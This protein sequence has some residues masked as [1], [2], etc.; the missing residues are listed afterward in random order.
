MSK[1]SAFGLSDRLQAIYNMIPEGG[2]LCDVGTDHGF[3]PISL[4]LDGRIDGALA[5]DLREG[6]LSRAREH[7]AQYH[8]EDRIETR[9]SDGLKEVKVGECDRVSISGMGGRTMQDILSSR[10][11][12]AKSVDYLL[13]QPQSEI[14]EFRNFLYE[15]GFEILKEDCIFEDGKFYFLILV[16][17]S[18]KAP[19][20][21]KYK[22]IDSLESYFGPDLLA[23]KHPVLKEYVLKEVKVAEYVLSNL[24]KAADTEK[25]RES[26]EKQKQYLKILEAAR[27]VLDI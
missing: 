27:G 10:M 26:K 6:P 16:C 14:P 19:S 13:L 3:L 25:N 7:V 12:V 2:V 23:T 22:T 21:S 18:E 4:C 9:L 15:E 24:S 8:L 1:N 20:D 17:P 11:D 5:M